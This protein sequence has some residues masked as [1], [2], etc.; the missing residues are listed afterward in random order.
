MGYMG[1]C[2]GSWDFVTIYN[3]PMTL[4]ITGLV[5]LQ[6]IRGTISRVISTVMRG[7]NVP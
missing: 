7:Y 4:L 5:S 1:L 2:G 3:W 6:R